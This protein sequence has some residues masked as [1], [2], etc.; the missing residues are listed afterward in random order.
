GA[1]IVGSKRLLNFLKNES[2]AL[3]GLDLHRW[4]LTNGG[5]AMRRITS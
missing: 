1:L 3:D 2:G 4:I 5:D